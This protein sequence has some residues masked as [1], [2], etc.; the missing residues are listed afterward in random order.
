[1]SLVFF[2]WGWPDLTDADRLCTFLVAFFRPGKSLAAVFF[3]G[4]GPGVA[5]ALP[6]TVEDLLDLL[7]LFTGIS[8][9][10]FLFRPL[11]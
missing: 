8:S 2:A 4:V 1:M 3:F 6:L 7:V 10:C 5:G 11:F 9:L